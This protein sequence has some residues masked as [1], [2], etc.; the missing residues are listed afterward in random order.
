MSG[1]PQ[2]SR[3]S[4]LSSRKAATDRAEAK[5]PL[6]RL[7]LRYSFSVAPHCTVPSSTNHTT[8]LNLNANWTLALYKGHVRPLLAAQAV[9]VTNAII[10]GCQATLIQVHTCTPQEACHTPPQA[11][12]QRH[13][14]RFPSKCYKPS[15]WHCMRSPGTWRAACPPLFKA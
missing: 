14:H 6:Y 5:K 4:R 1:P 15:W 11:G 2:D 8:R 7:F 10:N 9:Q 3:T 12:E 13:T